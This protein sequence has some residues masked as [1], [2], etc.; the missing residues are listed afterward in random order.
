M[1]STN[2]NHFKYVAVNNFFV[3]PA[4]NDYLLAR[5][6][7]LNNFSE[8]FWHASQAIEKY[9]KAGLVLNG[10]KVTSAS[11]GLSALYL[12][13]QK[14]FDTLAFTQFTMPKGINTDL[15]HDEAVRHFICRME[16]FGSP[17]SRYGLSS[18][19]RSSDDLFKID[20]ICWALRRLT[21]GLNWKVGV[22]FV[23]DPSLS[24]LAGQEYRYALANISDA[25]P[26]GLIRNL[27]S[28]L[29]DVGPQR[30]DILHSWNFS[31]RRC[32][33]D[34]FKLAP[35]SIAPIIGPMANSYISIYWQILT[36]TD[37]KGKLRRLSPNF[38]A[39]MKWL[40]D[41]IKLPKDV[42]K[43]IRAKLNII[44]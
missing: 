19:I 39:G 29:Y 10:I 41:Y 4:D 5:W 27:G 33:A 12:D 18:W 37:E 26:R 2:L 30:A 7:L 25:V 20:Q 28:G 44:R 17:D 36:R 43:E 23:S 38:I 15:W 13:H 14:V 40:I 6:M 31:F 8:F 42:S 3:A 1:Q 35:G 34:I 9:L 32:Q 24:E 11:H 22:D 21:I 16:K